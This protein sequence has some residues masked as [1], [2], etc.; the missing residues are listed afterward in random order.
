MS[1][2]Y[3]PD[4]EI[5]HTGKIVAVRDLG[6]GETIQIPAHMVPQLRKQRG[7]VVQVK[8]WS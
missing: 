8:S 4:I 7:K 2:G 5:D 1:A 6:V 3:S